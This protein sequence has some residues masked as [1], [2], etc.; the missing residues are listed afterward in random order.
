MTL[1]NIKENATIKLVSTQ[2]VAGKT[3]KSEFLYSC[4]YYI[5]N[6]KKYIVYTEKKDSGMGD[7]G[8]ILKVEPDAVTMRRSGEFAC[9]MEYKQGEKTEFLYRVP[10][11]TM[12]ME[13]NTLEISD[14]LSG[15]GGKLAFSY[16]LSAG[17]EET[18]TEISILV[19]M[20]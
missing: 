14:N 19:E 1:K 7:S 17:G 4:N 16:I 18:K 10:Y 9:V 20:K 6:G 15:N 2:T 13:I 12:E 11:G 8:V 3:E 5:K